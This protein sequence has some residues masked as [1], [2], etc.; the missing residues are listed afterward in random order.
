MPANTASSCE[1][2]YYSV[3]A[4]SPAYFSKEKIRFQSAIMPTTIQPG[5]RFIQSLQPNRF[6]PTIRYNDPATF[7]MNT[8]R[9]GIQVLGWLALVVG[10]GL[11]L[12]LIRGVYLGTTRGFGAGRSQALWIVLGYLLFLGL[13]IYLFT[14]GR[15]TLS[16]AK[17]SPRPKVR[18][19]WGRIILGTIFLYSSAVSH[20]HL[21]PVRQRINQLAP[22]NETQAVAMKATAI[23][24]AVG[25]IALVLSGVWR[26]IRPHH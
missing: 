5:I 12:L 3:D 25:C 21:I 23:L 15:R 20:F 6:R 26:G 24:L 10:Y 22:T 1:G 4:F 7:R 2:T 19:G 16:V 8:K 17:G 11:A 14:L 13:A 18:F 9:L